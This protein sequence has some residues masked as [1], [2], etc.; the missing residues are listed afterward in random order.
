MR[1]LTLMAMTI[2]LGHCYANPSLNGPHVISQEEARERFDRILFVKIAALGDPPIIPFRVNV[3]D[4]SGSASSCHRAIYYYTDAVDY[5]EKVLMGVAGSN[6]LEL[7]YNFDLAQ[8]YLCHLKKA[9]MFA[10]AHPIEGEL[11]YCSAVGIPD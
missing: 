5:C 6:S 4:D 7:A 1:C 8:Q 10:G 3:D 9:V 11:H 2:S